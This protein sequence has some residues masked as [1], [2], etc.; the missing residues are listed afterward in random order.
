MAEREAATSNGGTADEVDG[1]DLKTKLKLARLMVTRKWTK[2]LK[3]R[4]L[5]V[6][7]VS[8]SYPVS[9]LRGKCTVMHCQDNVDK[10]VPNDDLFFYVLSYNPE[11]RRL[12]KAIQFTI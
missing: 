3:T 7:E 6:S 10:F 8:E 9:V 4:E 1:E 11:N 2:M 5:F 12:G